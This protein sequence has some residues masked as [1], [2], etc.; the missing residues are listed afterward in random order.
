M[1]L[2]YYIRISSTKFVKCFQYNIKYENFLTFKNNFLK[3]IVMKILVNIIL[4]FLKVSRSLVV[5]V[6][7][8]SLWSSGRILY[9][10]NF[11]SEFMDKSLHLIKTILSG[12]SL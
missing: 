3:N 2:V 8:L 1:C 4:K 6:D 9:Y 7:P 12:A 11:K 5:K 10:Y